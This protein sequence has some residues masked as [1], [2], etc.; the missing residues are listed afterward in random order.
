MTLNKLKFTIGL[1]LA[2]FL[3]I[4]LLLL[5]SGQSI[6]QDSDYSLKNTPKIEE[7][8]QKAD[9]PVNKEN[10]VILAYFMRKLM[11]CES[12][13]KVTA[14]NP[15][16]GGSPSF[17]LYQWKTSSFYAYNLKYKLLP[18]IEKNEVI[19]IIYDPEL[20]HEMTKLVLMEKGGWRNWFNCS[21]SIG[22]DKFVY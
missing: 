6:A 14:T 17:G 9:F 2:I 15:H 18:D 16:D 13:G 11:E 4:G 12:G 21:R 22:L 1:G 5:M 20:Q 8:A 19:N 7:S 10:D 3:F